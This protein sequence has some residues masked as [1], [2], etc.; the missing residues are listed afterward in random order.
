MKKNKKN[1]IKV[2]IFPNEV[3]VEKL[4]ILSMMLEEIGVPNLSATNKEIRGYGILVDCSCCGDKFCIKSYS[5]KELMVLNIK[6]EIFNLL[7]IRENS[8]H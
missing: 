2:N 7:T 1:N 8:F 6:E 4:N 3:G 5:Y